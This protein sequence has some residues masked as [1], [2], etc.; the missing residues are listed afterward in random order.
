MATYYKVREH[1][2]LTFSV[3]GT[4]HV[5]TTMSTVKNQTEGFPDNQYLGAI[6]SYC[7]GSFPIIGA[8]Q[9]AITS[10]YRYYDPTFPPEGGHHLCKFKLT[11]AEQEFETDEI[12]TATTVSSGGTSTTIINQAT[13]DCPFELSLSIDADLMAA[14]TISSEVYP[15]G[16]YE[17]QGYPLWVNNPG[18]GLE[19]SKNQVIDYKYVGNDYTVSCSLSGSATTSTSGTMSGADMQYGVNVGLDA[20]MWADGILSVYDVSIGEITYNLSVDGTNVDINGSPIVDNSQSVQYSDVLQQLDHYMFNVSSGGAGGLSLTTSRTALSGDV[21]FLQSYWNSGLTPCNLGQ[22]QI[23][24]DCNGSHI[25]FGPTLQYMFADPVTTD[26]NSWVLYGNDGHKRVAPYTGDSDLE[27]TPYDMHANTDITYNG[28]W[29]MSTW[30]HG[31]IDGSPYTMDDPDPC[32]HLAYIEHLVNY[33]D[34]NLGQPNHPPWQPEPLTAEFSTTELDEPDWHDSTCYLSNNYLN[35]SGAINFTKISAFGGKSLSFVENSA[36][37]E[38]YLPLSGWVLSGCTIEVLPGEYT[39]T[40]TVTGDIGTMTYPAA[41]GLASNYRFD[42]RFNSMTWQSDT[43]GTTMKVSL[44]PHSW[45]FVN[46]IVNQQRDE[47]F[48]T[49]NPDETTLPY[50]PEMQSLIPYELP[51]AMVWDLDLGISRKPTPLELD[52]ENEPIYQWDYPAGWGLGRLTELKFEFTGNGVYKNDGFIPT[53]DIDSNNNVQ[54]IVNPHQAVW[55]DSR[56]LGEFGCFYAGTEEYGYD[57][58][59]EEIFYRTHYEYVKANILQDGAVIGQIAGGR[60][61]VDSHEPLGGTQYH[62]VEYEL[63]TASAPNYRAFR[64]SMVEGD[65]LSTITYQTSARV[66]HNDNIY[67]TTTV[68]TSA[69]PGVTSNWIL[70]NKWDSQIIHALITGSTTDEFIQNNCLVAGLTEGIYSGYIPWKLHVDGISY[71]PGMPG[72]DFYKITKWRG[73]AGV[74]GVAFLNSQTQYLLAGETHSAPSGTIIT[75]ATSGSSVGF[76]TSG[77]CLVSP[78]GNWHYESLNSRGLAVASVEQPEG[79]LIF[80]LATGKLLYDSSTG[81]LLYDAQTFSD[82]NILRNRNMTRIC[83]FA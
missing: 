21:D 66:Y 27:T 6:L 34:D 1:I 20:T 41:S 48:D 54:I 76:A 42:S 69:E 72:G 10:M 14:R 19:L 17:G 32:S 44:G 9:F 8:S 71:V 13:L 15:S 62:H 77:T 40:V 61:Y 73:N 2:P 25:D 26:T 67:K 29:E 63:G 82:T 31:L 64:P 65:W 50:D 24:D 59:T 79:W 80:D 28:T 23:D 49:L 75:I 11:F 46:E 74:Y 47:F 70:D 30:E 38:T 68:S 60:I 58:E 52:S 12:I 45:N 22:I 3:A 35:L 57:D 53:Y 83:L 16:P 51:H 36:P 7:D 81:Q 33:D 55:N 56:Q 37:D 18:N 43:V 39:L 5:I 78:N 4:L